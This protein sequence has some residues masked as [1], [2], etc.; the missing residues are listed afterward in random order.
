MDALAVHTSA[1]KADGEVVWSW[2]PD[3]GIKLCENVSQGDGGYQARHSGES[4]K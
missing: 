3:A 2:S 4:T 1:P